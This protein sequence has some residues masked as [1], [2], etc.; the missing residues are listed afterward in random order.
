[1]LKV[2][3]LSGFGGRK[4]ENKPIEFTAAQALIQGGDTSNSQSFS[5]VSFG[6]ADPTRRIIVKTFHADANVVS[7]TIGGVSATEHIKIYDAETTS[8]WSASVPTGTT[9]TI[10]IN[11]DFSN[12]ITANTYAIVSRLVNQTN[13]TPYDTA[14]NVNLD[15]SGAPIINN[16][17]IPTDG[18]GIYYFNKW[19]ITPQTYTWSG[20]TGV[21]S[22][23]SNGTQSAWVGSVAVVNTASTPTVNCNGGGD[24]GT[25]EYLTCISWR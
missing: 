9:G 23:T 24:S 22:Y 10:V 19:F 6:A 20:A 2:N 21:Y 17:T 1:M 4:K 7:M 14:A 3:Q 13:N 25:E 5:S 16:L 18:I 8:I 12:G 15:I 11:Y